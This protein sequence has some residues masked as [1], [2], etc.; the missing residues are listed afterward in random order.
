MKKAGEEECIFGGILAEFFREHREEIVEMGIYEFDQELYDRVLWEDGEAIGM[1]KGMEK[2]IE[3]GKM[4]IQIYKE[5]ERGET[6]IERIA[7][8]I[9]S[10]IEEVEEIRKQFGI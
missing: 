5:I 2:G 9:G 1:K 4:G 6:D 7:E 8:S 3:M 10:S